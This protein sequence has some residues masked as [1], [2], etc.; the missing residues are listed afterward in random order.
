MSCCIEPSNEMP[1][2][3]FLSGCPGPPDQWV[4][5]TLRGEPV[6]GTYLPEGSAHRQHQLLTCANDHILRRFKK[7]N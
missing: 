2:E 3:D 6:G 7:R 1:V 4:T 5:L